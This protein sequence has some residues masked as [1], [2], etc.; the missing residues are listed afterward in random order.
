LKIKGQKISFFVLITVVALLIYW[1]VNSFSAQ[2][3][4]NSKKVQTTKLELDKPAD[5]RSMY[6][7]IK[8]AM[9]GGERNVV[10]NLLTTDKFSISFKDFNIL[11]EKVLNENPECRFFNTWKTSYSMYDKKLA[12]K[13]EF[14]LNFTK[15]EIITMQTAV[16]NKI[17]KIIASQIT[18]GMS[19]YTKELKLHDYLVNNTVYD[20]KN[21]LKN[22]VP[23]TSYTAYGVLIK[24]VGVCEGYS[25][26]MKMLLNS[27]SIEC[28]IISGYANGAHAWNLVKLGSDYYHLDVTFDDPVVNNGAIN[29]LRH[30]YFNITDNEIKKN[31][32]WDYAKYPKCGSHI[33]RFTGSINN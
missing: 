22:T 6:N 10:F 20:Y 1:N 32:N 15:S 17:K 28:G 16:K 2:I 23:P 18:P 9:I 14:Q 27:V 11:I 29:V 26:A 7:S 31:H 12:Y 8:K 19:D 4:I 5:V 21:L 30:D 13:V 24:G 25:E 33:Y 3:K